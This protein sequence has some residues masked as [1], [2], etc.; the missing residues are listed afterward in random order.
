MLVPEVLIP[1]ENN[2]LNSSLKKL[3]IWN[4][5]VLSSNSKVTGDTQ[6]CIVF[7]SPS[8]V[9]SIHVIYTDGIMLEINNTGG[10]CDICTVLDARV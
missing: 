5:T 6:S 3:D 10:M 2:K 4:N 1:E 9:S 8:N 7:D